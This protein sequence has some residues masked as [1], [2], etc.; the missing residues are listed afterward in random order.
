MKWV[1]LPVVTPRHGHFHLV[2]IGAVLSPL[3]HEVVPSRRVQVR[4]TGYIGAGSSTA[5]LVLILGIQEN[6][7]WQ[8]V[9]VKMVNLYAMMRKPR[10]IGTHFKLSKLFPFVR[11]QQCL[12]PSTWMGECM[13]PWPANVFSFPLPYLLTHSLK[14]ARFARALQSW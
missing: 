8:D 13:G 12:L 3:L 2:R 11:E 10:T 14:S 9:G 6:G 7:Y 4:G 5:I 1:H